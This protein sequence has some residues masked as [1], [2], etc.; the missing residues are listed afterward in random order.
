MYYAEFY[1]DAAG[2]QPGCG[3]RS[4]LILDGREALH[5]QYIYAQDWCV[6]HNWKSFRIMKGESFSRSA[7]ISPLQSIREVK[8]ASNY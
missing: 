3:D 2:N 5:S 7:A 8:H 4:V 1:H 6:K